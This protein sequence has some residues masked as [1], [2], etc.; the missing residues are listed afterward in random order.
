MS[1]RFG[2]Y[3]PTRLL[4]TGGTGEVYLANAPNAAGFTRPVVLKVPKTDQPY[5]QKVI[6][7]LK[8]EARLLAKVRHSQVASLYEFSVDE[9][10]PFMVM[11]YI[12][13]RSLLDLIN[14]LALKEKSIG[15]PLAVYLIGEVLNGLEYLHRS[16]VIHGDLHPKN[17]MITF[18]GEVKLIDFGL[19]KIASRNN[20]SDMKTKWATPA[21]ASPSR[22][23]SKTFSAHDDIFGAG[24]ILWE[25]C[26]GQQ[27]W[28]GMTGAEIRAAI[29]NFTPVDPKSVNPDIPVELSELITRALES[30]GLNR[31]SSIEEF[32]RTLHSILPRYNSG[33]PQKEL[34][35][36]MQE[37]FAPEVAKVREGIIGM[38][39]PAV[40]QTK[41]AEMPTPEPPAP[42][43]PLRSYYAP[44]F[45]QGKQ[46]AR[47]LVYI[48]LALLGVAFLK[49][50]QIADTITRD[51][52]LTLKFAHYSV[53][54]FDSNSNLDETGRAPAS[55]TSSVVVRSEP[56]GVQLSLENKDLGVSTPARIDLP[57]KRYALLAASLPGKDPQWFIVEPGQGQIVLKLERF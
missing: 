23:K 43:T 50:P 53:F 27:F 31:I 36:L 29:H 4:G 19:A 12:E 56:P 38:P 46:V 9:G 1:K 33:F 26:T 2:R 34:R 24:L 7:S 44:V 15:I 13:G 39:L 21:Y 32:H 25:L 18:E 35:V 42:P 45:A 48:E 11:E 47:V 20:S 52:L 17:I 6:D 54:D 30:E 22:L 57:K 14:R 49:H 5:D 3:I 51:P 40:D 37:L 8:S 41:T 16:Q 28:S 55:A 10:T